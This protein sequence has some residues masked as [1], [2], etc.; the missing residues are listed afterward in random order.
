M[1]YLI[2][3]LVLLLG[4]YHLLARI[5]SRFSRSPRMN[6]DL[7][8]FLTLSLD[9]NTQRLYLLN[10]LNRLLEGVVI[11]LLSYG[12]GRWFAQTAWLGL[13]SVFGIF[14][15][16]VSLMNRV[17]LH[18]A[19]LLERF[20]N[21]L[22]F[23]EMELMK[24]SHQYVALR[25]AD[26]RTNLFGHLEDVPSYIA[27]TNELYSHLRWMV[28]KKMAILLERN[29]TFSTQDLSGDFVQLAHELHLRYAQD[30]RMR[31]ERR[32][33]QMIIPMMLNMLLMMLY[34]ISPF[35]KEFVK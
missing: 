21:F 33:N 9:Q 14:L 19:I 7:L 24:G 22:F 34:L 35:I 23:Y 2:L 16:V 17:K 30:E 4:R 15:F 10:L 1:I 28:V 8:F 20:Q 18:Q 13:L 32:E 12:A 5:V 31:L 3:G 6:R 25:S 29:Q 11:L 27:A 26:R